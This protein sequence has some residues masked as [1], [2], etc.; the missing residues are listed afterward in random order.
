[1]VVIGVLFVAFSIIAMVAVERTN[2]TQFIT[3]RNAAAAQLT[4]LSNAILDYAVA[5]ASG[6]ALVYPCP[7]QTNLLTTNASFGAVTP[8]CFNTTTGGTVL[9]AG[10]TLSGMVPVQALAPY[11]ITLNDAFDPWDNRIMYVVNRQLTS[12]GSGSNAT[13]PTLTTPVTGGSLPGPDFLLISYGRDGVGATKRNSTTVGI[14]CTNGTATRRF[15]NC[16]TDAAFYYMPTYTAIGST[17]TTYY[18]D[19]VTYFRK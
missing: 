9:L 1:M 5:N 4:K 11:G 10:D 3:K 15:E 13:N 6:N 8:S 2:A 16:D 18:D 7:A 14:A 19:I 17:S 12:G